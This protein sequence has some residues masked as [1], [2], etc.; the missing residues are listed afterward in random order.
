M[1]RTRSLWGRVRTS[2]ANPLSWNLCKNSKSYEI[3]NECVCAYVYTHSAV[4]VNVVVRA[5]VASPDPHLYCLYKYISH[6]R[7]TYVNVR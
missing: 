2:W 4:N 5:V 1:W 7:H 3:V 6:M